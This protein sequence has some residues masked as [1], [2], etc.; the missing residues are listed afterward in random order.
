MVRAQG[1]QTSEEK[2]D[3]KKK[4]SSAASG[5]LKKKPDTGSWPCKMDGCKKVFAREADLKRHQ[6]TTKMHSVPG[7]Q[8]PQCDA[9]FTRTDALRRHQKSRHNGVVIEPEQEKGKS[10]DGDSSGSRSVSPAGTVSVGQGEGSVNGSPPAGSNAG[11]SSRT[12]SYYRPHTIQDS[13]YSGYPPPARPP[14]GMIMDPHYPPGPIGLPTSAT[15]GG[16]QNPPAPAAPPPWG[17]DGQGLPQPPP[18][19]YISTYYPGPY[20]RP[21]GMPLPP[22]LSQI[23]PELL[24]QSNGHTNGVGPPESALRNTSAEEPRDVSTV[25]QDADAHTSVSGSVHAT[26]STREEIVEPPPELPSASAGQNGA[27]GT[28][29]EAPDAS[30]LMAAAALQAVLAY[31]KEQEIREAAASQNASSSLL[32]EATAQSPPRTESDAAPAIKTEVVSVEQPLAD[33]TSVVPV[34][35]PFQEDDDGEADAI[36]E[37]DSD[38]LEESVDTQMDIPSMPPPPSMDQLVTEDGMPMLNPDELLTQESLASPP[39]S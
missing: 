21:P 6:R 39:P 15:R 24:A 18:G 38:M 25:S 7:F 33:G 28:V 10:V 13:Y 35:V 29:T 19:I 1:K 27:N 11:S 32:P 31:Q 23:N 20:Y 3:S 17:P 12:S 5:S 22:H 2:K 8:C 30:T 34:Q 16:W 4:T 36:G 26:S 14:P 9:T 37:P